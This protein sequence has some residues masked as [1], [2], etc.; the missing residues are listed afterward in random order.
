MSKKKIH[1]SW[2]DGIE[3]SV[4]QDQ[5]LSSLGMPRDDNW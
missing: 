4:F 1:N 5:E 2:D 3:K